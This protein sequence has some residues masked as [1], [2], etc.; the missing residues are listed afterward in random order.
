[1]F[2]L[3]LTPNDHL[4]HYFMNLIITFIAPFFICLTLLSY[5]FMM[6]KPLPKVFLLDFACYK[7]PITQICAKQVAVDKA[8]RSGYFSEEILVFMKKTLERSGLGDS[9]YLPEAF[10]R[11]PPNLYPS[12]KEAMREAEMVMFGAIDELLAKTNVKCKDIG[13]LVVNCCIFNVIPSMSSMI[14]N[15]YKLRD[16]IK[17]YNLGGMGCS[18]GLRAIGLAKQLLQLHHNTYALVMSTENITENCYPGNDRS[19]FLINCLFRVGGTAILLTNRPSDRDSSKYELMHTVHT[20]TARSDRSYNCIIRE[21]DEDGLVGVT[22]NKDLLVAAIN[23]IQT[24]LTRLAP[25]ILPVSEQILYVRNYIIRRFWPGTNII[26]PYIPDFK[27]GFDHFCSHVGG[28][29]VVDELQKHMRF[30]DTVMEATRMT[31]YRFG[32]LSSS[33][34]WYGLAYTEAKGRIK[35]GDRVWQIS[36]GSG[37][38]CSSVVWR[39]IRTIDRED[40]NP[41]T[42]EIDQFPVD[43]SHI[44]SFP[45]YFESSEHVQ[46]L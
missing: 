16:D 39:A 24:N 38:K 3:N 13:I 26:K 19:K 2:V 20:H 27:K 10:L 36:F 25:L 42:E 46:M 5:I 22:I 4:S 21:E 44:K 1:M 14:V 43:L 9:T 17:S 34:I 33:T 18:A 11:D 31:L 30:T 23:A 15:R 45:Y 6:K 8:R 28:K 35:K 32:N 7:P 37:F 12:M 41:W 29:M 40:M